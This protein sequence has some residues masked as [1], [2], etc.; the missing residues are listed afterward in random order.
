MKKYKTC[1]YGDFCSYE[2]VEK[3]QMQVSNL[4]IALLNKSSASELFGENN[5]LEEM[6]KPSSERDETVDT[7]SEVKSTQ[8]DYS[9]DRCN[10]KTK[11]KV[12]VKIHVGKKH[13]SE[14]EL[15]PLKNIHYE[16]FEIRRK[17][18]ATQVTVFSD[19]DLFLLFV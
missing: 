5:G 1:R 9:C 17:V 15:V 13:K 6:D 11:T 14:E 12:G 3:L 4:E 2:H 10:Y 18:T 16:H 7:S 8:E 19:N